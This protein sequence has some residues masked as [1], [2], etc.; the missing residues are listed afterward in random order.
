VI[1][2][3]WKLFSFSKILPLLAR[4]WIQWFQTVS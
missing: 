4:V 3:S 1:L 2:L